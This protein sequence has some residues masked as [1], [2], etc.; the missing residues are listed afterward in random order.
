MLGGDGGVAD[1][2]N[3]LST[4]PSSS[5]PRAPFFLRGFFLGW[6]LDRAAVREVSGEGLQE[7]VARAPTLGPPEPSPAH[8]RDCTVHLSVRTLLNGV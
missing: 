2:T 1:G 6:H 5:V 8:L 4:Q 3:R 7:A